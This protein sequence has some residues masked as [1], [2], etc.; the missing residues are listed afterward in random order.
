M[1]LIRRTPALAGAAILSLCS[2]QSQACSGAAFDAF[3]KEFMSAAKANDSQ[4]VAALISFPVAAWS[5]EGRH[6]IQTEAIKDRTEFLKRF[7]VVF[8]KFMRTH[9]PE[10]KILQID[11]DRCAL[12]W[13]DAGAEFSFEFEN[14]PSVGYRVRAFGIGPE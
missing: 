12:L 14:I 6:G 4:R 8:N 10:A 7:D 3:H 13:K 9:I 11:D 5:V 2:A 1:S